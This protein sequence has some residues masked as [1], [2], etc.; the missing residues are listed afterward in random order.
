[1][2]A[3]IFGHLGTFACKTGLSSDHRRQRTA[4][5]DG[6]REA[7]RGAARRRAASRR[8]R[9]DRRSR[10]QDRPPLAVRHGSLPAPPRQGR[11][12]AG[13]HR[14]RPMARTG[15][16]PTLSAGQRPDRRLPQR[17]R[18]S[19]ARSHGA[20][21]RGQ[22]ANRPARRD[23]HPPPLDRRRTR[24]P[25]WQSSNK[26]SRYGSLS[27]SPTT[28]GSTRPRA[29]AGAATSTSTKTRTTTETSRPKPNRSSGFRPTS[30]PETSWH[31]CYTSPGLSFAS[32]S[33]RATARSSASTSRCS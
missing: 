30:R 13:H 28:P 26:A 7:P 29:Y 9:R 4:N 20:D 23:P 6:Q 32:T 18:P 8:P 12:R 22:R 11:P 25:R 10:R 5:Q 31:R 15:H 33:A 14:T 24:L 27:R 17:H 2:S 19:R 16:T 21:A 3:D 1:M